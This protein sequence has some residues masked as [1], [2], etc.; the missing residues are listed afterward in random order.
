MYRY[1][2][3]QI[4]WLQ[5]HNTIANRT[6]TVQVCVWDAALKERYLRQGGGFGDASGV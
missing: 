2:A 3:R 5:S 6:G 1:Q 4:G